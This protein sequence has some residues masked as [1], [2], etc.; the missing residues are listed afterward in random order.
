MTDFTFKPGAGLG[1]LDLGM[2]ADAIKELLGEPEAVE[3]FVTDDNAN[4]FEEKT[5]S[6]EYPDM[7]LSLQFFYYDNIF[8]GYQIFSG[9]LV[10][11]G[12]NLFEADKAQ[13]IQVVKN[14]HAKASKAYLY[15]RTEEDGETYLFYPNIGLT[16]WFEGDQ[17]TDSC[18]STVLTADQL[19]DLAEELESE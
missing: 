5:V 7:E 2:E 12:Q 17:L 15:Q 10:V 3:E 11:D 13:V 18:I 9:K 1:A 8:E 14:L 19:D 6:Y 4:G 16:L